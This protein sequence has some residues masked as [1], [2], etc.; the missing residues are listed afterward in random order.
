MIAA[1]LAVLGFTLRVSRQLV[2]VLVVALGALLTV[3]AVAGFVVGD[4]SLATRGFAGLHFP[5]AINVLDLVCGL[6]AL[7]SGLVTLADQPEQPTPRENPLTGP[8][9]ARSGQSRSR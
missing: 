9:A 7:V 2:G 4:D 6:L 5:T 3:L 8:T 1:V